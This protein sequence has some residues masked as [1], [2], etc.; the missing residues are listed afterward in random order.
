MGQNWETQ[1]GIGTVGTEVT[2]LWL[3]FSCWNTETDEQTDG[4]I[5]CC[6]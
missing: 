1:V 2:G 3:W 4:H 5:S 6:K